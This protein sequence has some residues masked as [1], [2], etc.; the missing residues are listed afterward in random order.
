MQCMTHAQQ[1]RVEMTTV[2]MNRDERQMLEGLAGVD[3]VSLSDAIRAAIRDQ[4]AV[5]LPKRGRR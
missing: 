1:E 2:R 4:H 3:G 5:R